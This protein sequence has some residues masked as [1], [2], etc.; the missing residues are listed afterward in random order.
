MIE[1]TENIEEMATQKKKKKKTTSKPKTAKSNP[2]ILRK[3]TP[4]RLQ[5]RK[6]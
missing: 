1:Q 4:P 5:K 6:K 3:R 2:R